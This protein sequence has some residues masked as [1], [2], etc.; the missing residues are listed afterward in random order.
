[1]VIPKSLF[2]FIEPVFIGET[3]RMIQNKLFSLLWG[4]PVASLYATN[5]TFHK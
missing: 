4:G 5:K 3:S 1:M 2:S